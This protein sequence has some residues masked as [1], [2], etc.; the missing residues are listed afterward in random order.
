M[1]HAG[2]ESLLTGRTLCER[3]RVGPVIGRGG[4]GVVYQGQDTRLQR[5]V[6]IK[7]LSLNLPD[8]R[9]EATL[10]SRLAREGR[11]AAGIRHPNVVAVFDHGTDPTLQLDFLIMEL[12]EG[13]DLARRIRRAGF[14]TLAT[15]ADIFCAAADGLAAG[16]RVGLVHR[17]IKPANLFLETGARSGAPT[18]KVLDF[19]IAQAGPEF[20]MTVTVA[21]DAPQPLSPAFASLEQ[22]S[23]APRLT[24]ASDVYSLGAVAFYLLTGR[25]AF[26]SSEPA[27]VRWELRQSLGELRGDTRLPTSLVSI[28]ERCLAEDPAQRFPSA[29]ELLRSLR[30]AHLGLN[31]VPAGGAVEPESASGAGAESGGSSLSPNA[32]AG[33]PQP[34]A[35]KRA[36]W[37]PRLLRVGERALPGMLAASLA[38]ALAGLVTSAPGL[39]VVS[40]ISTMVLLP[41]FIH[42]RRGRGSARFA[43]L[44]TAVVTLLS[45]ALMQGGVGE[46]GGYLF[47]TFVQLVMASAASWLSATPP[48]PPDPPDVEEAPSSQP[49]ESW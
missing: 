27:E 37:T 12:L 40:V 14:P 33:A 6:A 16:H 49:H 47:V 20:D 44:A 3:Y 1:T 36:V 29:E 28:V 32:A 9:A 19:G 24:P 13:E 21:G 35:G 5:P 23:G 31:A 41:W 45:V 11:I 34:A 17:D 48:P 46:T 18:L 7:V 8:A 38:A 39:V 30:S 43:V 10:R 22:L 15:A 25:R 42:H 2:L 26:R 4:M